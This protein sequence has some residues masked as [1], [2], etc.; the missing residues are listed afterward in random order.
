MK[1]LEM[2]PELLAFAKAFDELMLLAGFTPIGQDE[3]GLV[4][5]PEDRQP[6][7]DSIA[8]GCNTAPGSN[9]TQ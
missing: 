3:F 4:W 1:K 7:F 2:T 6:I 8:R 9:T 5:S